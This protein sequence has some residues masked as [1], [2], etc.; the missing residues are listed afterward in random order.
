LGRGLANSNLLDQSPH[1]STSVARPVVY[2]SFRPVVYRSFRNGRDAP[3]I[4]VSPNSCWGG[5]AR[6]WPSV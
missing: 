5:D 4:V 2:R 3:C 1:A 6:A